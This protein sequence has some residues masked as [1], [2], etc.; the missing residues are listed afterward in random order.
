MTS[1]SPHRCPVDTGTSSS[2]SPHSV[3]RGERIRC[4]RFERPRSPKGQYRLAD[5]MSEGLR[6][7]LGE[8]MTH[9]A[10]LMGGLYNATGRP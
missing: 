6:H 9:T 5:A 10:T 2:R 3:R 4:R 8:E 1:M 7:S